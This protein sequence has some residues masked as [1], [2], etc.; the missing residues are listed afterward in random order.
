MTLSGGVLSL[1]PTLVDVVDAVIVAGAGLETGLEVDLVVLVEGVDPVAR[2]LQGAGGEIIREAEMRLAVERA[3]PLDEP[4]RLAGAEKHVCDGFGLRPV[5]VEVVLVARLAFE[6]LVDHPAHEV[7]RTAHRARA[8]DDRS[9]A[10][11]NLDGGQ[12]DRAEAAEIDAVVVG[13]VDR[14]A[15]LVQRYAPAI[16]AA[17]PDVRLVSR[18]DHADRG[19]RG[20]YECPVQ[21]VPVELLHVALG[22]RRATE[23]KA[24]AARGDIGERRVH[25]HLFQVR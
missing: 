24:A 2:S 13:E 5:R 16:E 19:A 20:E 12:V 22:D 17:D 7:H 14:D 11:R 1:R 6:G 25:R 3:G 8:I 23:G 15:V 10:F 4:V 21:S 9:E 18:A